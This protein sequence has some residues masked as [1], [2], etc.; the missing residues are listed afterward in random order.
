MHMHTHA[1]TH[2][3]THTHTLLQGE[4]TIDGR[5]DGGISVRTRDKPKGH[6][7]GSLGGYTASFGPQ[8]E[9]FLDAVVNSEKQ[10]V[11]DSP[12]QALQEVLVAQAVYKSAQTRQWESTALD[13]LTVNHTAGSS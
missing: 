8:M 12:W 3:H 10:E 6:H 7:Y 11:E 5:F 1:R 13:N 9:A 4:I 2:I